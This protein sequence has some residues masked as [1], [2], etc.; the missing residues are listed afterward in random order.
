VALGKCSENAPL[1][2][3]DMTSHALPAA[4]WSRGSREPQVQQRRK[5]RGD[6]K[7]T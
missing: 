5:R 1:N 4:T 3:Y 2:A 7:E 6:Y